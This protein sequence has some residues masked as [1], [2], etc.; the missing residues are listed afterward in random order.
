MKLSKTLLILSALLQACGS[1]S[2]LEK[3]L[4]AT[5]TSTA[6]TST[7]TDT[8]GDSTNTTG[9]NGNSSTTTVSSNSS[10]TTTSSSVVTTTTQNSNGSSTTQLA[11]G[12]PLTGT[13]VT[14]C[15]DGQMFKKVFANEVMTMTSYIFQDV[16]CTVGG[17]VHTQSYAYTLEA[18]KINIT[19]LPGVSYTFQIE[20]QNTMI[21]DSDDTFVYTR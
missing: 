18:D 7:A 17:L 20:Q 8:L 14:K 4:T 3:S 12:D 16:A 1:V 13:W 10:S 11:N 2:S 6:T 15:I 21:I 19:S 9:T 5:N